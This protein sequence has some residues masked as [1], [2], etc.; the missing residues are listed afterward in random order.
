MAE[1]L[2]VGP[3]RDR[4]RR[5]TR[6]TSAVRQSSPACVLA[7]ILYHYRLLRGALAH[8]CCSSLQWLLNQFSSSR[9]SNGP[10]A[11]AADSQGMP[12]LCRIGRW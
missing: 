3:A 11:S 4:N 8:V 10:R 5:H 12:C 6:H 7:C 9:V 2:A 1:V